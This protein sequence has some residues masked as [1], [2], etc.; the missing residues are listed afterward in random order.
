MS[1]SNCG[2]EQQ[3]AIL[4]FS[5]LRGVLMTENQTRCCR[6]GTGPR[7]EKLC[8]QYWCIFADSASEN[9]WFGHG[10]NV[11]LSAGEEKEICCN[12]Q[13]SNMFKARFEK[14]R[15]SLT[16][17]LS[18]LFPPSS[19]HVQLSTSVSTATSGQRTFS[20]GEQLCGDSVE[21]SQSFQDAYGKAAKRQHSAGPKNTE[22]ET[23]KRK[24][25]QCLRAEFELDVRISQ[26]EAKVC[27]P[28]GS[29]AWPVRTARAAWRGLLPA[30]EGHNCASVRDRDHVVFAQATHN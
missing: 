22:Q 17:V 11:P 28:L 20:Q 18:H 23:P 16:R 3:E 7:A 30:D 24:E 15:P 4:L 27:A 13:V 14:I 19:A 21:R 9:A 6:K 26:A 2:K 12:N 29:C 10:Q 8:T 1:Q 5:D 25:R